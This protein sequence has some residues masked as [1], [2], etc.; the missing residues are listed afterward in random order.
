M[1]YQFAWRSKPNL[2]I[3]FGIDLGH[4][5]QLYFYF[6]CSRL[7]YA[8]YTSQMERLV[9]STENL[10]SGWNT[11]VKR[12]R[13]H[14]P[15]AKIIVTIHL[16]DANKRNVNMVNLISLQRFQRRRQNGCI[17]CIGCFIIYNVS[18]TTVLEYINLM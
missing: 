13:K 3:T 4:L 12:W 8:H 11:L 15:F 5:Q 18:F 7:D 10:T 14:P 1:Q 17:I 16:F 6:G 9:P 2:F